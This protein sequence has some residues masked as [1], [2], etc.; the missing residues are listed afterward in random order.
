VVKVL[1][2]RGAN[3]NLSSADAF[4]ALYSAARGG[5]REIVRLLLDR[6]ADVNARARGW[7]ARQAAEKQGHVEIVKLLREHGATE[8]GE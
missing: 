4:P 1:L 7:S 8:F 5:H 2:E 6:G 3:V